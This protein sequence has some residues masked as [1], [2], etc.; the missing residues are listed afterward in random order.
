MFARCMWGVLNSAGA[1]ICLATSRCTQEERGP[2]H[3][4]SHRSSALAFVFS[5]AGTVLTLTL[6]CRLVL[7][8]AL[9]AAAAIVTRLLL[10]NGSYTSP[11]T[12]R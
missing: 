1:A 11:L 2:G 5:L 6:F 12:H 7:R 3:R 8:F 9:Y 10:C 4:R